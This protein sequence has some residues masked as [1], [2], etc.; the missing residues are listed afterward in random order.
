MSPP[1]HTSTP[2]ELQ[3]RLEVERHGIPFLCF[4]DGHG[5]QVI[6]VLDPRQA[7]LTIGRR[8][9]CDLA[10]AWDPEVSRVH[11][12]LER[13]GGEWA[14]VDDGLSRNGS[15]LNGERVAGRRR[16]RDGD[17]LCFGDVEIEY[18]APE[19]TGL[20]ST[21][22]VATETQAPPLTP[23]QHRVL[24]SL[25]RP[26]RDSAYATPATNREI[27]AELF[28]SVDAVKAHLRVLFER[29]DLE[30]LPQNQKRARL[31]ALALVNGLVRPRDF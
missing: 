7:P 30:A 1:G 27:S 28:L 22:S 23:A 2:R 24:V 31:A 11:A 29:F 12:Q 25:C 6:L 10:L 13:V 8:P 9:D 15:W 26:L 4:R 14:V 19:A 16:L 17:R 20:A 18:R 5:E 21:A 3:H